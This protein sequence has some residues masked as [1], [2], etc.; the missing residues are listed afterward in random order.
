MAEKNDRKK[1]VGVATVYLRSRTDKILVANAFWP[2]NIRG[3]SYESLFRYLGVQMFLCAMDFTKPSVFYEIHSCL[4]DL[5]HHFLYVFVISFISTFLILFI[6]YDATCDGNILIENSILNN[7]VDNA[8]VESHHAL[9]ETRGQ[10][11]HVERLNLTARKAEEKFLSVE[12][13]I[14]RY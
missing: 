8:V 5:V 6:L 1:A 7:Y 10:A 13:I 9:S 14:I 3:L 2:E 12:Q 4:L 11:V